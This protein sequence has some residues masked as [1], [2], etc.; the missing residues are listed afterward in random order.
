MYWFGIPDM[1]LLFEKPLNYTFVIENK[2]ILVLKQSSVSTIEERLK[3]KIIVPPG[4]G[5]EFLSFLLIFVRFFARNPY[6]KRQKRPSRA[7]ARSREDLDIRISN[8]I[9]LN[10]LYS[11]YIPFFMISL[12][13]GYSKNVTHLLTHEISA[14]RFHNL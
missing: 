3:H 6:A 14:A 8:S 1:I 11:I 5:G 7:N 2:I 12:C 4:G 13:L 10:K 9:F